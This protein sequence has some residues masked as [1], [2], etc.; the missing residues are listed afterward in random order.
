AT[1]AS[2]PPPPGGG[3]GVEVIRARF[4]LAHRHG[5][6]ALGEYLGAIGAHDACDPAQTLWL[7][8]ETTGLAGGTGT[9]VFLV[10]LASLQGTSLVVEQILLR[11]LSAEGAFLAGLRERLA[12]TRHLVTFNGQR[13]DWPMLEARFILNRLRGVA[14]DVHTDLIHSARRLWHRVLGTH[15][16]GALE[17]EILG[18]PRAGDIPGYEIPS[19][20]VHYLRTADRGALEPILAHNRT[21]LLALI[22]LHAA[23]AQVLRDPVGA[24]GPIDWEGTGVLLGRRGEHRQAASCFER[25]L[26]SHPDARDRW[27]ILRRC[28]QQYRLLGEIDR[29]RERLEQERLIWGPRDRYRAHLL[30]EVTRARERA[31][32]RAGALAAAEEALDATIESGGYGAAA[33]PNV[34]ELLRRKIVRLA[35]HPARQEA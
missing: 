19:L 13:F 3:E 28:V 34:V 6:G 24:R 18:A 33:L 14:V 1:R 17:T 35:V 20:Y 9:Y 31:G 2:V 5:T 32:D 4:S 25:A 10:G 21:D 26:R 29:V 15:R 16:L 11:R 27:R 22:G 30:L 8:T 12:R 23:V 7:D